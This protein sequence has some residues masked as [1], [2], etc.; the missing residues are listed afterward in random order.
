MSNVYLL[1]DCGITSNYVP[2][3]SQGFVFLFH[4]SL[5][6]SF[7]KILFTSLKYTT[8]QFDTLTYCEMITIR[9]HLHHVT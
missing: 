8:C 3:I 4:F 1:L 6:T 9:K 7:I 5:F 2:G